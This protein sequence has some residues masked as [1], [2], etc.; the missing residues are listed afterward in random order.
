MIIPTLA[1]LST[2]DLS[3]ITL[4]LKLM[5]GNQYRIIVRVKFTFTGTMCIWH[6]EDNNHDRIYE[7]YQGIRSLALTLNAER[8]KKEELDTAIKML[9]AHNY[10]RKL[11]FETYGVMSDMHGDAMQ[12]FVNLLNDKCIA[13]W[14]EYLDH[15]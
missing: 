14:S 5:A 3:N 11:L 6:I 15:D 9:P 7:L 1:I 13:T 12:E 10:G 8:I 2:L 4:S